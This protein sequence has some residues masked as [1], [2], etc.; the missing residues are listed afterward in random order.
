MGTTANNSNANSTTVD[1]SNA[2][3]TTENKPE[4]L[5]P[6]FAMTS[7]VYY[8]REQYNALK[9]IDNN[10]TSYWC[11]NQYHSDVTLSLFFGLDINVNSV[12][13]TWKYPTDRV[14]F[15]SREPPM[16]IY[17]PLPPNDQNHSPS[18]S[19]LKFENPEI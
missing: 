8:G 17:I 1:N 19:V 14:V 10:A 15:E 12:E 16:N 4:L 9:A 11:T 6:K 2:N 5:T 18:K 7:D 13:I 3:S